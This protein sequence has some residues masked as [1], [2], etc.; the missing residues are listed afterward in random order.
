MFDNVWLAMLLWA[1]LYVADYTLTIQGARLYKSVGSQFYVLEGSYEI[2]PYY[3]PDVD[4]LR[5][6]S[7]RFIWALWS[8]VLTIPIFWAI[9]VSTKLPEIFSLWVGSLILMSVIANMRHVRTIAQFRTLTVPDAVQGKISSRRW[10]NLRGS[11][12][13][14][15]SFAAVWFLL[16]AI[17]GSWFFAGGTLSCLRT[18]WRHWRM[19]VKA[20]ATATLPAVEK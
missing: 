4:A 15:F 16:F 19:S 13:D 12:V 8:G 7:R 18:G 9:G 1:A 6:I 11:A 20:R 17:T 2:T 3:Q 10:F 5:P 14:L